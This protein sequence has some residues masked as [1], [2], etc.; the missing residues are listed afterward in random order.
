MTLVVRSANLQSTI[1]WNELRPVLLARVLPL[2]EQK[3]QTVSLDDPWR[4]LKPSL[5]PNCRLD[6]EA[7]EL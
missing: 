6:L 2:A 3:R 7:L 4:P 5:L 1:A